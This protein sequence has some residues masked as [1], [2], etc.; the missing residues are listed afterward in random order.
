MY[1]ASH[2]IPTIDQCHAIVALKPEFKEIKKDGYV[3]FDYMLNDSHTFDDPQSLEMRGIAFNDAGELCGLVLH[4]F[5]N[6]G[7][8]PNQNIVLDGSQEIQEKLDGSMIR[9]I[10]KNDGWVFGTRAGETDHSRMAHAWLDKQPNKKDYV[11]FIDVC[12]DAGYYPIFEFWS[13]E[14]SVV[15]T[16]DQPFLKCIAIRNTNGGYYK[17]SIMTYVCGLYKIPCVE[18][19]SSKDFHQLIGSVDSMKGIEGF[20]VRTHGDWVKIKTAEYTQL[21]KALDGVK[22]DKDVCLMVLDGTIDD[23]IAKLSEPR[24]SQ[25]IRL[26]DEITNAISDLVIAAVFLF[27]RLES[28]HGDRK[29]FA[30]AAMQTPFKNELFAMLDGKDA[31]DVVKQRFRKAAGGIAS[32][33]EF[34][35]TFCAP[36]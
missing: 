7:E 29:L 27:N 33:K 18:I 34:Y 35:E 10:N 31:I 13:Q 20:V 1:H 2:A 9:V 24:K 30:Q 11:E 25:V 15:I 6:Y 16:Y 5:F 22:F 26:R 36:K 14:N 17:H 3:V 4:K 23:V 8:K 19:H 12:L 32:W 28:V 21:H